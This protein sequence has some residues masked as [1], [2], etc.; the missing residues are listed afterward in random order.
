MAEAVVDLAA[1][2]IDVQARRASQPGIAFP[3]D[4]SHWVTEFEAA[5]PYHGD[6]RPTFGHRGRET[7][8][9]ETPADGPP[10]LR[11]RRLRQNRGRD[12]R[13]FKAVD[14][15]KQVAVLVPTTIL[16]EQ[17]HRSFT[18]RMAEFPFQIEVVNRFRPKS[19]IRDVLKR[20]AAGSV[21]ILI[22][23]HRIVQKDVSFKDLGLV[24]IDEEQRFGVEDKEW[25]KQL[26]R[27]STS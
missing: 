18:Q 16:A 20:T 8:H 15:G 14:A 12:A 4:D 19:E 25:L 13:A 6:P 7:R 5:F 26:R 27:Q 2:L 24:V 9:G 10:D 17:H 3:E 21:D 22:G 1:E 11:R 23:T